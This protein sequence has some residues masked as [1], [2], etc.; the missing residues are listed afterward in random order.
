LY[1]GSEQDETRIF[2]IFADHRASGFRV[3]RQRCPTSGAGKISDA[4]SRNGF[5]SQSEPDRR[6]L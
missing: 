3:G 4:F 5:G 1:K 6:S 2:F